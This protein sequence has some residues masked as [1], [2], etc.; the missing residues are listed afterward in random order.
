MNNRFKQIM[1]F[2]VHRF[3]PLTKKTPKKAYWIEEPSLKVTEKEKD[4]GMIMNDQ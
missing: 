4:L 1:F 3:D 2:M